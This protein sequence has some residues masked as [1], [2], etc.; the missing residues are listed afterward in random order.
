MDVRTI[1][2]VEPELEHNGTVPVWWM[3]RPREMKDVLPIAGYL[4]LANQ[5]EVPGRGC[6]VPAHAPDA[7]VLLRHAREG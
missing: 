4:E 2:D 7:R 1:A 6:G 3:I 5:F